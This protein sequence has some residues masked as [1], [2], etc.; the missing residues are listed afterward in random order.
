MVSRY[1]GAGSPL[2]VHIIRASEL[3]ERAKCNLQTLAR[4]FSHLPRNLDG[5]WSK[6]RGSLDL[7]GSLEY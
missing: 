7:P 4:S 1:F 3:N 6:Q 5:I 2:S